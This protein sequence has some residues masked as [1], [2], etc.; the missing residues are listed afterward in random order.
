MTTIEKIQAIPAGGV[1]SVKF[2]RQAY[3]QCK[4]VAGGYLVQAQWR[5]NESM[6]R[7]PEY[8]PV[9]GHCVFAEREMTAGDATKAAEILDQWD[10]L[11]GA[12]RPIPELA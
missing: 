2:G 8:H 11:L 10:A 9:L 7:D 3:L 1:F 5:I 6:A 4:P 12:N